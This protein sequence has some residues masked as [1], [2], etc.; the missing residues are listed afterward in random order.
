MQIEKYCSISRNV[1]VGQKCI[2]HATQPLA[3]LQV[4]SE[5]GKKQKWGKQNKT[6]TCPTQQVMFR[7]ES[8]QY[9][10][11]LL[12]RMRGKW[13]GSLPRSENNV[14]RPM[15]HPVHCYK[16]FLKNFLS[17]PHH[18]NVCTICMYSFI[19]FDAMVL[20][21]CLLNCM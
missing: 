7:A 3:P 15:L 9:I 5:F 6:L 14:L 17:P 20:G 18:S 11:P 12:N 10:S 4:A 21:W 8:S 13:K 1:E 16:R 2:Q 19:C